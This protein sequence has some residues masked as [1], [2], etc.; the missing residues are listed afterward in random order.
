VITP[1]EIYKIAEKQYVPFL[2]AWLRE[3]SFFPLPIRSNKLLDS[4]FELASKQIELLFS[5]SKNKFGVGYTISTKK[6]HTNKMGS[7]SLPESIFFASEFDLLDFID[8]KEEFDV[9]KIEVEKIRNSDVK[10]IMWVIE[11]PIAIIE[12]AGKW[13]QLLEVCRCFLL[14]PRPNKYLRELLLDTHTKFIETNQS[15]IGSLLDFLLPNDV[16]FC[17][18]SFDK[19]YHLKYDL[20]LKE[21]I[22]IRFLD[23]A[24][25]PF[26]C[27]S[28]LILLPKEFEMLNF[29]SKKI[30]ITE[31]KTNFLSLP[32]VKNGIAIFGK[33]FSI[34][35]LK[36]AEWLSENQLI[37]WG[38]MDAHGFEI[39]SQIRGYFSDVTA[40]LMDRNI[41]DQN[42]NLVKKEGQF[43]NKIA[44]DNL[45]DAENIFFQYLNENRLRLE[46]EKI[47][48][49]LVVDYIKNL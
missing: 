45:T 39:L 47:P 16:N 37:Y 15:V 14:C 31:N 40:L 12:N 29:K 27:V 24:L 13:T 18:K 38:D 23:T 41:F 35:A 22:R 49:D 48:Y 10:I 5:Q 4:N 34:S 44:L 46:Q 33:G 9:F 3:E 7:Q 2:K 11:N 1:N 19:R 30:L 43:S 42:Q 17:E 6:V 25:Y 20:E 28:E 26:G 8:R 32:S 36:N 21:R